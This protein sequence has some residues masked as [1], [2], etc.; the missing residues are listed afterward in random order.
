MTDPHLLESL[1]RLE[2]TEP[3]VGR[4]DLDMES[5]DQGCEGATPCEVLLP[6]ALRGDRT[7]F[8]RQ[9]EE[10]WRIRQRLLDAPPPVH[11]YAAGSWGAPEADPLTAEHGG[12]HSAWSAS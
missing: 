2:S 7:R 10:T 4:I 8:T 3:E 12:W 1:S 6:A 9:G 11:A 5:A